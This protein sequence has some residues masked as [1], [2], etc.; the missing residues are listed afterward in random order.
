MKLTREFNKRGSYRYN[1][2]TNRVVTAWNELSENAIMAKSVN[3]FKSRIDGEV[4]EENNGNDCNGP[5]WAKCF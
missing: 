4:F 1:F 5:V 2:F 3:G